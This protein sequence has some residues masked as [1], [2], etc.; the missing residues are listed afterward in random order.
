[1]KI[2]RK[3]LI[4]LVSMALALTMPAYSQVSFVPG[5]LL[6]AGQLNY[7]FSNVLTLSGGALTG[8]L[9]VPAISSANATITG[10]SITGLS[11]P[12]PVASGGTGSNT[13]LGAASQLQYRAS[14][15]G[16]VARSY[17]SKFA[18]TVSVLDFGADPTGVVDSAP[19]FRSAIASNRRVLV[20]PGTYLF[21]STQTAPCCAFDPPA[22][23]VQS[24]SNFEIDGYGATITIAN[25]IAGP[26]PV[27]AFHF[28]KDSN[29]VVSGLT[30]QGNRAGLN[31]SQENV[32]IT[33]SSGVNFAIRSIHYTGDYSGAGTA[34]AGDWWVNGVIENQTLDAGGQCMDVAY[35]QNVR[36]NGFHAVG[37]GNGT[38]ISSSS[39]GIKCFSVIVDPPNASNNNTG[40]AFTA[41][42]GVTLTGFDA[43]NFNT[44]AYVTTG[45]NYSFSGNRWHDNPG[46]GT[47][48]GYGMY[49]V[50][51]NAVSAGAPPM[52]VNVAD[53]FENNG[54]TVAGAGVM[55][56]T[57]GANAGDVTTGINISRSVFHGNKGAAI[58]ANTTSN[59]A[60]IKVSGNVYSGNTSILNANAATIAGNTDVVNYSTSGSLGSNT[61][62][63]AGTNG[64]LLGN[65]AS[66]AIPGDGTANGASVLGWNASGSQGETDFI[67]AKGAGTAGGFSWYTWNGTT[68]TLIGSLSPAGNFSS[69]G[70]GAMPLFSVGG[71]GV[72]APHMVQGTVAL[73]SGSATVTLSGA[74]TFTSS[75]SYTCTANDTSAG[76]AVKISQSS[77]TS[78]TFSGTS[79]DSVQFLCA[80]S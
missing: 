46:S 61:Q 6:T 80:G 60:D 63:I 11:A 19:A 10:G 24:Q 49:I 20:P 76:N 45:S 28:D 39:P 51:N 52:F 38:T 43:S 71:T 37:S 58:A 50:N 12:I 26:T 4:G 8:P 77:G 62:V 41:T 78:I 42:N 57:S 72:N 1:M 47:T 66:G 25:S 16:S 29:F 44:G 79:T 7:A 3:I 59:F 35:L 27:S 33:I 68:K 56:D 67:N 64:Y 9:T 2:V 18:E 73:S 14:V 36:I 22:V 53:T 32:G 21:S 69:I 34:I 70:T 5:Q 15:T 13:A 17:Q 30:I 40:V 75:S 48:P 31:A 74:A 65:I 55:L 23:L 54:A